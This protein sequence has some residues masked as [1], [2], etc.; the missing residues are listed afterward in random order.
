[1]VVTHERLD[2]YESKNSPR[3]AVTYAELEYQQSLTLDSRPMD[4][5]RLLPFEK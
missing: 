2:V 1:M 4:E 3:H 5:E